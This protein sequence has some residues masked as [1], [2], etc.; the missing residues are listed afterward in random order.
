MR[1]LFLGGTRFVG[2]AMAREALRRGHQ[3]SVFHRGN[4]RPDGLQGATHLLGDRVSDVHLLA[5]DHW[6]AVVDVCA[7]RPHE[8]EVLGG[9]LAE[10]TSVYALVSSV[11]VYAD[12]IP[13]RSRE[14]AVRASTD[15]LEGQDLRT[16]AI[17]GATYGPLK[18][19]CEDTVMERYPGHL[20]I[21]PSYVIGPDD[22]TQRFSSWV[23]RLAAG[24]VVDAPG[25]PEV[26]FQY[27]D[28]RDLAA[29][30]V[31]ALEARLQ[32]VF[33]VAAP[34]HPYSFEQM[35]MEVMQGVA[36]AGTQLRWLAPDEVSASGQ[37]FPL[38]SG[39]A[40]V[41]ALAVDARAAFA[42]GLVS[43]PLAHTARDVLQASTKI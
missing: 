11:S 40:S 20:I 1:I 31:S 30:A 34:S 29:F 2:L 37:S 25:P 16:V 19:L 33:H 6:D 36:P 28:V 17:D 14:D 38:W 43:R 3:V 12:D 42:N 39:G 5:H 13:P 4:H 10:R 27:I 26:P 22:Y 41:G 23:N 32:G 7:Y 18:V 9:I 15:I 21:R 24:G 8:I 35:L